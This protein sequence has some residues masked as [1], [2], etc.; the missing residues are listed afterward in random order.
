MPPGQQYATNVPQTQLVAGIT[1]VQTVFTVASSAGW[2]SV[3]FTAAFDLGQSN[4][5]PFDVTNIAGVTW[6]VTRNIDSTTAFS[7]AANATITHVDVGRDFR[8]PRAHIDAAGPQDSQGVSVHGIA[9]IVGNV[10]VGLKDTQTLT[11]KTHV[12]PVIS[13]TAAAT[14]ASGNLALSTVNNVLTATDGSGASYPVSPPGVM[15]KTNGLLAWTFDPIACNQSLTITTG[16]IV[17]AKITL[18]AVTLVTNLPIHLNTGGG[19]L[20]SNENFIGLYNSSGTRIALS[21]D[22]TAAWSSS[23]DKLNA[24]VTPVTIEPGDYYVAI[25]VNGTGVPTFAAGQPN[26]SMMNTNLV[27]PFRA[28]LVSGTFTA[29]PTTIT[30][31][32]VTAA[33]LMPWAGIS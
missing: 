27:A 33:V 26:N 12:G 13:N 30:L 16:Q 9:N 3:P 1:S 20:T 8:E 10:V 2:P 22:Q 4:Q 24:M 32:S 29:L 11:N 23:G 5:E 31:G 15:S 28:A 14:P 19:S 17:L 7:H 25:L 21:A 18:G 6:T